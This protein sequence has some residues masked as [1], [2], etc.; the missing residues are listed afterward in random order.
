MHACSLAQVDGAV[1]RDVLELAALEVKNG[2][3]GNSNRLQVWTVAM[4]QLAVTCMLVLV[5]G[6]VVEAL[7]HLDCAALLMTRISP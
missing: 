4:H 6:Q 3:T 7:Y 1:T 2:S 5:G